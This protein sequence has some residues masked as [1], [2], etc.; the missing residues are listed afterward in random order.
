[1]NLFLKGFI[2]TLVGFGLIALAKDHVCLVYSETDSLPYHY[3]LQ[4]KKASPQKGHYTIFE[5][6]WYGSKV[7]KEIVG[8]V[9]D[10]IN[11]EDDGSLWVGEQKIGETKKFARDGRPLSPL[12]ARAIPEG[13]VFLKG[14]HE[15]S[16]DSRY[17]EFG[18]IPINDLQGR[19]IG[20]W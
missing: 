7:I 17:E 1:M 5:C 15:R 13:Y 16:F 4:F 9:G 10:E 8:E 6:P 18:L 20:V 12:K 11:H 14:D 19:V 2:S 3:F